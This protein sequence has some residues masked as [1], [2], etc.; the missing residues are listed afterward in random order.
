ML[1]IDMESST[2]QLQQLII[3]IDRILVG[4]PGTAAWLLT[5]LMAL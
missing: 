2:Q 4:K 5:D 1:K 3:A